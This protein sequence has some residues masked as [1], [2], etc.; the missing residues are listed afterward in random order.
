L[1]LNLNQICAGKRCEF[2][3]EIL[4]SKLWD[5]WNIKYVVAERPFRGFRTH[6]VIVFKFLTDATLLRGI[7][8]IS[9]FFSR[10][11]CAD[12]CDQRS[13]IAAVTCW[14]FQRPIEKDTSVSG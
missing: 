4:L 5:W 3:A 7:E 10:S 8:V 1:K 2:F 6:V 11:E 12:Q 13:N 9:Y 14:E